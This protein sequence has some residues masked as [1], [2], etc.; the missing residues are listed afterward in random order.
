MQSWNNYIY[1]GPWTETSGSLFKRLELC[2]RAEGTRFEQLLWWR[3]LSFY[4]LSEM[5]VHFYS[6]QLISCDPDCFFLSRGWGI[7]GS[8]ADSKRFRQVSYL[9]RPS[10]LQVWWLSVCIIL[11]LQSLQI[12]LHLTFHM[13]CLCLEITCN[14]S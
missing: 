5:H 2:S 6:V 10:T 12:F 4:L 8:Q 13:Y 14:R 1:R 3:V 9:A 7:S 11:S